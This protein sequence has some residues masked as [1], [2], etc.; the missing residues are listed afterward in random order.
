MREK[1]S[2][3]FFSDKFQNEN[4][5]AFDTTVRRKNAF[6][7]VLVLNIFQENKSYARKKNT[8]IED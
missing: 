3:T 2:H 1:L 4:G 8:T 5:L 6:K 7:N